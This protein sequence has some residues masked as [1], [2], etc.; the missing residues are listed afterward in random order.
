[1][2]ELNL[3][4]AEVFEGFYLSCSGDRVVF[5][6]RVRPESVDPV[7]AATPRVLDFDAD[8]HD[9]ELVVEVVDQL[10]PQF[11]RVDLADG[12]RVDDL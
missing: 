5:E 2:T 10:A 9:G 3:Q 1:M 6:A 11:R 12:F 4:L 7:G 8:D